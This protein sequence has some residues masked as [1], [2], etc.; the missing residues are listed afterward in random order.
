MASAARGESSNPYGGGLGTGGKFRKQTARK[1]QK[2]P[3]D[4]PPTSVRNTGLGGGDDRGGG[5]LSKL[6]DPAQRLITYSAHRLFAS[7]FRK[8]LGSGETP[9]QSPEQQ[10]Q[11]PERDVDEETKVG[12][13]QDNVSNPSMKNDLIQMED[14]NESV[15]PTK[16]GY[17]DLEKILQGKTFTRSEVDRLTTLLRSKASD[18]STVNEEQ[19]NEVSIVVR[20]PPSHE[21]DRTHPNNGSMNAIVSTPPGSSRA[22]VECGA[23][24]AQLAKAYMG[25]RPSEVTP[26]MLGLRGQAGR[27]DSVFLNRTP[28]PQKS[29]TMSLVPK[30]SGQRV[31][32]NGYVTPRSRGRSAVYSMARTPYSRPQSTVKIGSLFQASPGTWEESLPSGSRQGFQSGLKRRS[33]VLDNDIGSVGPVRR[34]RQKS[35]LSSRSL[36][37][38]A[39]ES[40]LSVRANGG[41]KTTHTSRDSAKDIPGSSFKLVPT[42]SSDMASKI[43]Q[44]LDNLV[45]TREKSPS[46]LSPSMLRGPALKS[47]ENVEAPKFL[48]NL[49]KKKGKLPDSGCQKQEKS[50]ESGSREVL[51]PSEKVGGTVDG[52]SKTGSSQDQKALGKGAYLPLTSSLEEHPPKKR[53]FRMSA[54]EDFLDL[55]D[56]HGAASTPFEVAEKQNVFKVEK[57]RINMPNGEKLLTPSEAMPSTS[58]ISNGDA[59][60]STSNGSL[61]TGTIKFSAFPTEA[62]QLSN[63]ASEPTSKFTQGTEKSSISPGQ[64]TSK[65]KVIPLEEPKKTDAVFPSIFSS[66]AATDL[67]NQNTG[68]SADIK[69]EKTSSSGF[70]LSGAW[71]K[72]SES[73][74]TFSYSAS[75]VES[76]TSAASTLNGS[77]F[78]AGANTVS[79]PPNNG[80]FNSSPSFPS[81]ISSKPSDN[82]SGEVPSTV[83]SLAATPNS[84]SIFGKLP[85]NTSN[86]SNSQSTAAPPASSS[87]PFKFGEPAA[88]FSASAVTQSS[89]QISKESE[90]KKST[91]ENTNT[92]K[93]GGMASA[94]PSTG[95]DFGAKS[96][97]NKSTPGFVFGSPS[98]AL[99]DAGKNIFGGTSSVVGGSTLNP[100]TAASSA[101]ASSGSLIF[102]VTS[103]ST[104]ATEASKLSVSSAATNAGSNIFGTSSPAFTSSGSS[105]FGSVA[106]STGS[107]VFGFN[108]ASSASAAS[109]QSQASNLFGAANAQTGN[110]GSGTATAT[111]S[112]PFQFGSSE[113]APSFG[114]SGSSSLASNSSPFGYS[115]P[116]P[117][118]FASG[119]TPQLSSIN[120][121]ASSSGTTSSP[122]FGSSWPAPNS[123]PVFSSSFT[124][125]SSPTFTF[126]GSSA[127]TGSSTPAPIFGASTNTPSSSPIFGFSSTGPA[128]QQPI[129]GN[130]APSANPSQSP[131]GN[132][133][134]GFAFGAPNN[135][136]GISNNQQVSMED[137]M[138]EDTDQANKASMVAPMFGQPA[139]SMPQPNFS[140]GG[141]AAAQPPSMA[142]PFQFGGQ[143][144]ASTPQNASPFQASQ[145]LEF[146][147]GGS[148]SLG[149]TGGGD[150]SGR[151]IFKAKKTNRKK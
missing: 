72:P 10:K 75:G 13:K 66:P 77:I 9:L 62:V 81:S 12:H 69:L 37:L 151:R 50:R 38:P 44:H 64:L 35:N 106:A 103:S 111:Q 29:P 5:W 132:S 94:Q 39:S 146:Q 21:R 6:V 116:E 54:H 67:L 126:G 7:V 131:F 91:F 119:S 136:N 138:A 15:D 122:L 92:F 1:S 112:I 17:T 120:S 59:S 4:R 135:T 83:Q 115:K 24:P 113:S 125:A 140:F 78:S 14:T 87:S 49:P 93:F 42:Q 23:S 68:A 61:E 85:A 73:K 45:S 19:R 48:D 26:S 84:S 117:T 148:F 47:L 98:T 143:P 95:S 32:E 41:Q 108:A 70:G 8:R 20:H 134:P 46:K 90:V 129:F 99:A 145:S 118:V 128:T 52:T 121:S 130:T 109:S 55:D 101:T 102:G 53:A 51:A 97:E 149:S 124:T 25:S 2:T 28:F 139:V 36:A 56:D 76:T 123:A 133:T 40:P 79:L 86:D 147:G 144:M 34:I 3:Y 60:Q 82:S 58:Y 141:G 100:S 65:E 107:S 63:M 22:L 104:P 27:E 16:G 71:A 88:P 30:P 96:S 33:S 74:K 80:S 18:S 142:N 137:S 150:K 114:L 105:M 127:A 31:L 89:G 43:F 110:T 57:S 11:F